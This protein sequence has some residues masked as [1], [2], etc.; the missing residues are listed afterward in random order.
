V[1]AHAAAVAEPAKGNVTRNLR[2]AHRIIAIVLAIVLPIVF[3]FLV[4]RR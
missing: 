2:R 4:S 3:A 1:A